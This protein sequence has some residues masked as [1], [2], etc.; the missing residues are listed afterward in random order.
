MNNKEVVIIDTDP[1]IDDA[2][3]L[4]FAMNAKNIAISLITTVSGN[5]G[6]DNVTT[7]ALR[8]QH[9]L[10]KKI[11]VAKGATKPLVRNSK[12][13]G[14][15]HGSS[16]LSGFSH[17]QIDETLLVKEHAVDAMYN[18]LMQREKTTIVALG[19]LTNIALLLQK[20][21][22]V[23]SK[24]ERIIFMGGAIGRGNYGV[25][26]EFNI[27]FDPEA[28]QVVINSPIPKV[29]VGLEIGNQA[30]LTAED[31]ASI[32][33]MSAM[34]EVFGSLFDA[35]SYSRHSDRL[36]IYDATAVGY[37]LKPDLFKGKD[38]FVAVE[39]KG[40]YTA[41]ATI[42]DLDNLLSQPANTFVCTVIDGDGFRKWFK[43]QVA[44]LG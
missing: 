2:M 43:E 15:I 42:V 31:M 3:A 36:E 7:N 1:G 13:A 28:A 30:L 12:D 26:T 5:V 40:E 16:G 9:F 39:T 25:Y 11:P 38:V 34:G 35:Y 32:R 17:N 14:D 33:Q 22:D 44:Q 27:G 19:P 20:Y 29:M 37:L 10:N 6:I 23:I 21:P 4:M 8:L 41:G 18:D 24:V